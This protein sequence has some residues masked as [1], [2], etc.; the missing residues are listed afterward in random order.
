M[1]KFAELA[2]ELR[3]EVHI[4]SAL[5]QMGYAVEQHEIAARL[6]GYSSDDRKVANIIVRKHSPDPLRVLTFGDVGFLKESSGN[7]KV[8]ID[9]YHPENVSRFV[10]QV[11][12]EYQAARQIAT[13]KV[14][15]YLLRSREM[16]GTK[17]QL[18]FAVR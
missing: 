14:K 1:S 13:A 5:K 15:G 7:Y 10:G 2:T 18:R 3:D 6:Q 11:K 8:I 4:V 9:D 16:V 17:L 12:Q